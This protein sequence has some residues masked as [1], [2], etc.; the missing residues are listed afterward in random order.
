[1]VRSISVLLRCRTSDAVLAVFEAPALILVLLRRAFRFRPPVIMLDI[2]LGGRWAVRDALLNV[3]VP[4]VDAIIVLSRNQVDHIRARWPGVKHVRFVHHCVDTNLF[5]PAPFQPNGTILTV[6]DDP[7]RDFDTLLLAIH[8]IDR[9]VV[10]RTSAIRTTHPNLRVIPDR[11]A[12]GDYRRLLSDARIVVIPLHETANASGV[13]TLL[14]AMATERA[15]I[16][17]DSPGIRDYVH[18]RETAIVVPPHNPASLRAAIQELLE[19]DELCKALAAA[20]R[21]F[22]DA[23]CSILV[24]ATA[25]V[26]IIGE[27][28]DADESE[29][30]RT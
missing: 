25:I 6:G 28:I 22:V 14:E 5:A 18:H 30:A 29:S 15:V 23:N 13:S 24:N 9:T 17:S 12:T 2:G 1:V 10:A 21:A 8:N 4:R 11:L 27:M 26:R 7:G 16:V 19:D 20:A 3:V